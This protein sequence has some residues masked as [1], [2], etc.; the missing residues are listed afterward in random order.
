MF[1]YSQILQGLQSFVLV[2]TDLKFSITD[3]TN[4][5]TLTSALTVSPIPDTKT[6]YSVHQAVVGSRL[7]STQ[8]QMHR[9]KVALDRMTEL[10]PHSSRHTLSPTTLRDGGESEV[11]SIDDIVSWKLVNHEKLLSDEEFTPTREIPGVWRSEVGNMVE[12]AVQYI[13]TK[14]DT[15]QV[16]KRVVN[17]YWRVD[18]QTAIHYIIDFETSRPGAADYKHH[19]NRYRITFSRPLNPPEISHTLPPVGA[20]VT[21]VVCFTSEHV[22]KLQEFLGRLESTLDRDERIS[23]VAVQMRSVAEKQKPRRTQSTVDAKS[24]FSLYRSKY[25]TASFTLLE[26]PALLSRSHTIAIALRESRPSE[27]LFLADLDLHFDEAFLERCRHFPLQGQQTYF[28][29]VFSLRNP[30]LLTSLNHSL[31]E[32]SVS[33]HTGHW[34]V[35][36]YSI[37]CVFAADL[38]TLSSQTE[39]KGMLNEVHMEEVHSALLE[40]GY[41][42][43]RA[44]DKSL[45]RIYNEGRPCDLDLIGLTVGESCGAPADYDEPRQYLQTRLSALLFD[46]EGENSASKY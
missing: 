13:S 35:D 44:P 4:A 8:H 9:L 17:T 31:I 34:L 10:L 43:I 41:E 39:L 26:S 14:E 38:L 37:A 46:H 32:G 33:Q 21:I 22:E 2:D 11:V 27:I 45:K 19:T 12:K 7:N 16:Y 42:I 23:L 25:T 40:R 3:K 24:L 36:S 5:G 6:M 18:P 15:Q 20:H 30:A 1:S 28:P 29:V